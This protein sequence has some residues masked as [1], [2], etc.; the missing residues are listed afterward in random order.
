MGSNYN[1][2]G[3]QSGALPNWAQ[4]TAEHHDVS[5]TLVNQSP[6]RNRSQTVRLTG[7]VRNQ[8]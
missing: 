5:I 2:L 8:K 4:V 1:P 6:L 7:G 3:Q